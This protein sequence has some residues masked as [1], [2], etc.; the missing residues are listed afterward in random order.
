MLLWIRPVC[1]VAMLCLLLGAGAGLGVVDGGGAG[2]G[3]SQRS[4]EI[5]AVR[6]HADWCA[7]CS[8]LAPQYRKL[9]DSA[10]ELPV[11]FV[12]LDLTDAVMRR[13]SEYL[14][15]TLGIER[16]WAEQ[17]RVGVI[18]L[19]DADDHRVLASLSVG[20]DISLL[21]DA[22]RRAADATAP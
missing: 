20:D 11:L 9:M 5:I 2:P 13:Q 4:P 10:Q 6:F 14:A 1:V 15:S 19:L 12:T 18:E 21:A 22:I 7:A 8:R 16:I 3:Q 17:D